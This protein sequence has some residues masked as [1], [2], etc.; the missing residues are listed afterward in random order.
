[1]EQKII[2]VGSYFYPDH[3]AG[4]QML[5]DLSFYLAK[6][7]FKVTVITSRR[8]YGN[9]SSNLPVDEKIRGVDIVRA[10]SSEFNRAN[11]IGRLVN[12]ITMGIFFLLKLVKNVEN[13]SI[14]IL[15]TDPPLLNI[16]ATPLVKINNGVVINWIQDLFPEVAISAGVLSEKRWI[17]NFLTKKRNQSLNNASKNIVIGNQM[18]DY[19]VRSGVNNIVMIPNWASGENIY[20]VSIADNYLRS[21]WGLQNKFVIGYSGNLG[22]AHDVQTILEVIK[23]LRH[24]PYICFLFIGE[25]SGMEKI[26]MVVHDAGYSNVLFKPYQARENLHFSLSVSDVHWMT[27]SPSMEGY[28]VPSKFYGIL[29]A[30]RPVIFVG[31]NDGEIASDIERIKCGFSINIGDVKGFV[32]VVKYLYK[33]QDVANAMGEKGRRDFENK[34]DFKIV[35]ETFYELLSLA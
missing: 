21:K 28:I 26:K 20:P 34:Y 19:L 1:M 2:F 6:R 35:S 29:A 24:N 17:S 30:S 14:V 27:L 3:S 31:D 7:G 33:S 16:I 25:G 18:S 12:Y 15:M 32:D 10:W 23:S 5:S 4:S 8:L 9:N 11:C 22:V 13:G